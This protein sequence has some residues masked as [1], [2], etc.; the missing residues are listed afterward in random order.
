M[1]AQL[2]LVAL[3]GRK[4]P[5]LARYI[6]Q[7]LTMVAASEVGNH[8]RPYALEQIHAT[9]VGLERIPAQPGDGDSNLFNLNEFAAT[10][11]RRTMNLACA[12]RLARMLPPLT[13]RFGGFGPED[14]RIESFGYS[15]HV[16]S[17]QLHLNQGRVT[18]IGWR[19]RNG[20]FAHAGE[21]WAL[22][23]RFGAQCGMRPKYAEDSDFFM[24][25]GALV[26]LPPADSETRS[27]LAA[28]AA[29]VEARIRQQIADRSTDVV[30]SANDLAVV[31]YQTSDLA[32]ETSTAYPIL[33]PS[34]TANTL[35]RLYTA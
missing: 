29:T 35:A 3:Y 2:T 20:D 16:R 21:L 6:D 4:P 24:T 18:I 19:H 15:P 27:A 17:F 23:R 1:A 10:G 12:L 11:R 34:L 25:L 13:I 9:V 8:F 22:R 14:R 30:V 32:P 7:V 5:T 26:D 31:R 28:A 33:D